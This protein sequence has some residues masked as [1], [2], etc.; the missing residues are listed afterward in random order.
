MSSF[1][2]TEAP[3]AGA[4]VA[5]ELLELP[6]LGDER[7]AGAFLLGFDV[8]LTGPETFGK[9]ALIGLE[10][11]GGLLFQRHE[12]PGPLFRTVDLLVVKAAGPA[13]HGRAEAAIQPV[14]FQEVGIGV[15]HPGQE[16]RLGLVSLDVYGGGLFKNGDELAGLGAGKTQPVHE[17]RRGRSALLSSL[18]GLHHVQIGG[19]GRLRQADRKDHRQGSEVTQKPCPLH[20]RP[21]SNPHR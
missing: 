4:L 13:L 5:V 12:L 19:R 9:V 1:S 15:N 11:R 7:I 20:H 16:G 8:G 2:V 10:D 17:L 6:A 21:P 3:Q 18:N 14:L